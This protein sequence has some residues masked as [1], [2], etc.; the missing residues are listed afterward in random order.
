MLEDVASHS[1]AH[2]RLLLQHSFAAMTGMSKGG[3]S[4]IE[5]GDEALNKKFPFL[6][7]SVDRAVFLEHAR[8]LLL[9]LPSYTTQARGG[10]PATGL[11]ERVGLA[12]AQDLGRQLVRF[13]QSSA[14]GAPTR[15]HKR[16]ALWRCQGS[17]IG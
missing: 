2:Q 4:I 8:K 12:F 1:A 6:V 16:T 5:G 14:M 17:C 7:S 9:W 11:G 13:L 15:S 3:R 10:R